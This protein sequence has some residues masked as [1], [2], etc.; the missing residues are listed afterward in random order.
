MSLKHG[1]LGLLN[2]NP[3]TG[4]ELDKAFKS[5][6][7]YFWK[8]KASQIYRELDEMERAGWLSSKRVAQAEK[9]NKRVYSITEKGRAELG[10]WLLS[11]GKGVEE[12][13]FKSAFL[14]RVFFAAEMGRERAV[15]MLRAFREGRREYAAWLGEA[16]G[17]IAQSEPRVGA[18]TAEFWKIALLYGETINR[19]EL[20]WAR[21]AIKTLE[22]K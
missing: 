10:G 18:E 14:M 11:P 19:A 20:E 22:E 15:E 21:K 7:A 2:Y 9:P 6:L 4:Y 16:H 5:S 17:V 13:G 8:A 1:L 12:T 3:A